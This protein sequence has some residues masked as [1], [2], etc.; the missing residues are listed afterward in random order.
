MQFIWFHCNDLM[1]FKIFILMLSSVLD[2]W[3]VL[4]HSSSD[5]SLI[6]IILYR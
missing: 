4:R 1:M 2:F 5:S 3:I 6:K